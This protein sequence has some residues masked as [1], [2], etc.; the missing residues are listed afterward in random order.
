MHMHMIGDEPAMKRLGFTSKFNTDL[1]FLLYLKELGEL[2]AEKWLGENLE[3]VGHRSTL[4][5]REIFL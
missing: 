3:A 4:D 2:A 5:L 1:A